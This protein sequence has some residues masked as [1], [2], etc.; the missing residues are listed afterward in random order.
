[1]AQFAV[2][3]TGGKMYR[4]SPG[5]VLVVERVEG[6]GEVTLGEVLMVSDE[7]GTLFA[8][9]NKILPVTVKARI[10]RQE[11]DAKI[12]VFKKKKRKNYRRKQGHRQA[13]SRIQILEIVRTA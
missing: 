4:V 3:R 5:Q 12:I 8:E 1:M 2:V 11:R 13:V 10:I 9:G 7:K 6:E